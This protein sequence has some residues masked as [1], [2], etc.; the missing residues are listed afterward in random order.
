VTRDP[1]PATTAFEAARVRLFKLAYRML[2]SVGDA[3]DAVQDLYLRW[4]AA[5]E[6]VASPEAWL[7]TACARLCIDRLRAAKRARAAYEGPWLPEPIVAWG[8]AG[9]EV[10]RSDELTMAMLLVLERLTPRERRLSA[11]RGLR[12]RL[13]RDRRYP[14]RLARRLPPIGKPRSRAAFRRGGANRRL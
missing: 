14:G 2:G 8:D 7:V 4:R 9:A 6:D 1:S 13:R 12:L 5:E 10:E 3:E 11:A